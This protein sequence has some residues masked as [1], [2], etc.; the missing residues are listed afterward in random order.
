MMTK[1]NLN[2][3]HTPMGIMCHPEQDQVGLMRSTLSTKKNKSPGAEIDIKLACWGW[4][5]WPMDPVS[6]DADL[7]STAII[8][9]RTIMITDSVLVKQTASSRPPL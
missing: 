3:T 5:Q 2:L 7:F 8:V 6:S 9:E 1:A 4:R